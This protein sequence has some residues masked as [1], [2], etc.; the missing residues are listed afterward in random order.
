MAG[1]RR[2]GWERFVIDLL[3]AR[4]YSTLLFAPHFYPIALEM[5]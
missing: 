5:I 3:A 4:G 1:R 2:R